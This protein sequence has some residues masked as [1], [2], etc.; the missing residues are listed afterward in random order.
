MIPEDLQETTRRFSQE[1]LLHA[2]GFEPVL[3]D[4]RDLFVGT[5]A[6]VP[7]LYIRVR[8]V[9]WRA[10]DLRA[11]HVVTVYLT[12]TK[13]YARHGRSGPTSTPR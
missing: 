2:H 7:E 12:P 4:D 8:A 9:A 3:P 10:N 5:G 6:E 13:R 11:D 1:H